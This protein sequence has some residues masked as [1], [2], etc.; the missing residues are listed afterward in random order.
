M[1]EAEA[2][3]IYTELYE[4]SRLFDVTIDDLVFKELE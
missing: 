3:P 4:L 1:E 2:I